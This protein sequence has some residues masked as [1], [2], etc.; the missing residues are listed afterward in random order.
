MRRVAS[1]GNLHSYSSLHEDI[2]HMSPKGIRICTIEDIK[3]LYEQFKLNRKEE[4][5][6][7]EE[8]NDSGSQSKEEEFTL[9]REKRRRRKTRRIRGRRR[10]A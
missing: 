7:L 3:L 6:V 2:E 4:G 1:T 9:V 10:K 8:R 5:Q